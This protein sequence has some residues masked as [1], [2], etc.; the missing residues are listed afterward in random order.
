MSM[1]VYSR[2]ALLDRLAQDLADIVSELWPCI[3]QSGWPHEGARGIKGLD[4][5]HLWKDGGELPRQPRC[6]HTGW[7]EDYP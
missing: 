3:R 7:S 2:D 4:Q 5:G 6:P 1:K